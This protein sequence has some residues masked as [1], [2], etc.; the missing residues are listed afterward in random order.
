[1]PAAL[2]TSPVPG[3]CGPGTILAAPP[4]APCRAPGDGGVGA[5]TIWCS[6]GSLRGQ[7]GS[8]PDGGVGVASKLPKDVPTT[9]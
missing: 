2:P 6:A 9:P 4:V 7:Q 8:G 5:A 3:V 1:M